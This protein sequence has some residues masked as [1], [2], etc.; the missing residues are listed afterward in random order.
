[1]GI[2]S[3]V[4]SSGRA[5]CAKRSAEALLV[6]TV[7]GSFRDRQGLV[8]QTDR[9]ILGERR[10]RASGP[11]VHVHAAEAPLGRLARIGSA[12]DSSASDNAVWRTADLDARAAFSARRL[13]SVGSA[14]P[15]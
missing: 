6:Q 13:L 2:G 4:A 10:A 5:A 9:R 11:D 14:P 3:S 12:P 7:S 15:D 1:L 8:G